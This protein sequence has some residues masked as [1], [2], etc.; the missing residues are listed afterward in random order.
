MNQQID[1]FALKFAFHPNFTNET[2]TKNPQGKALIDS[3]G[4]ML[5]FC[6]FIGDSILAFQNGS[7]ITFG[8]NFHSQGP[9]IQALPMPAFQEDISN[10]HLVKEDIPSPQVMEDPEENNRY[11]CLFSEFHSHLSPN[12]LTPTPRYYQNSPYSPFENNREELPRYLR[13]IEISPE[14]PGGKISEINTHENEGR[15]LSSGNGP[16][17]AYEK[18]KANGNP[19]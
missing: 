17:F 14:R 5:S 13:Q 15:I 4:T 19:L 6:K 7:T 3:N 9:M 18:G 2:F 11:S 8:N 16:T 12:V 10:K 1:Q